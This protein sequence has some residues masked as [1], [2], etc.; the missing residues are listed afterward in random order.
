MPG[1]LQESSLQAAPASVLLMKS[2]ILS[3]FFP[4][5]SEGDRSTQRLRETDADAE[6]EETRKPTQRLRETHTESE[7]RP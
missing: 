4:L 3:L 1:G 5:L 7:E 6:T 2:V